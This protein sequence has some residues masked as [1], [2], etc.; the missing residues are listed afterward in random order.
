MILAMA[1]RT[2]FTRRIPLW[3]NS[4][5]PPLSRSLEYFTFYSKFFDLVAYLMEQIE[6]AKD[7]KLKRIEKVLM[8]KRSDKLFPPK[9]GS[10]DI[11]LKNK[12]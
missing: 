5:A 8:L 2:I 6:N 10:K 12:I 9:L 1:S 11:M 4:K 3:R 7:P